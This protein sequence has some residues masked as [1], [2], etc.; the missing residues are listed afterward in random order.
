MVPR[1]AETMMLED[2]GWVWSRSQPQPRF[3]GGQW[4]NAISSQT[5][6]QMHNGTMNML[7]ADGHAKAIQAAR[8]NAGLYPPLPATNFCLGNPANGNNVINN[9]SYFNPYRN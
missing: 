7:F 3:T 2:V 5:I 8:A 6:T 9:D 1:P 4:C